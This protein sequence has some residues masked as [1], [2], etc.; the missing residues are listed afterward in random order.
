MLLGKDSAPSRLSGASAPFLSGADAIP[1][2][3]SRMAQPPSPPSSATRSRSRK[4]SYSKPTY[5]S[6]LVTACM[7]AKLPSNAARN[8]TKRSFALPAWP[9][10]HSIANQRTLRFEFAGWSRTARAKPSSAASNKLLIADAYARSSHAPAA[11]ID[12]SSSALFRSRRTATLSLTPDFNASNA[13]FNVSLN[14]VSGV[15]LLDM[16]PRPEIRRAQPYHCATVQKSAP[17]SSVLLGTNA[18]GRESSILDRVIESELEERAQADISSGSAGGFQMN[19]WIR[20][21]CAINRQRP[22][23]RNPT[24]PETQPPGRSG[25]GRYPNKKGPAPEVRTLDRVTN[26]GRDGRI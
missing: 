9:V 7:A 25:L 15:A 18:P 12:E 21:P 1:N 11:S 14:T 2:S 13:S 17:C 10:T 26:N 8:S 16:K 24:L 6:R 19:S 20:L 22:T 23:C 5:P 4:A 3:C